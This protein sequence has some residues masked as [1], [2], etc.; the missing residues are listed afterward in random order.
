LPVL[1]DEIDIG[2]QERHLRLALTFGLLA[3][4]FP[5]FEDFLEG[6][7]VGGV[8]FA[9]ADVPGVVLADVDSHRIRP[10]RDADTDVAISQQK[11]L[12]EIRRR[13]RA[14]QRMPAGDRDGV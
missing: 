12:E 6:L 1:A 4:S 7:D 5:E 13:L 2:F 3:R 11:S 8:L 9:D 10:N 14:D